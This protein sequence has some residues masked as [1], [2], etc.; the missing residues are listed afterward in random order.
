MQKM[1]GSFLKIQM[2]QYEMLIKIQF[3]F[4][5]EE[6]VIPEVQ[7]EIKILIFL[8]CIS[9]HLLNCFPQLASGPV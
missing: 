9:V 6:I 8:Q 4:F 5:M 2:L 1:C 3:A 7:Y